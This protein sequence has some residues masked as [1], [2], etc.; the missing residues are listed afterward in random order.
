[1]GVVAELAEH[2]T[3][4]ARIRQAE[5]LENMGRL[6]GGVAHDFNNLLTGMHLYC[7]LLIETLEPAHRG[8]HY[9]EEIRGAAQ[10]AGA[11]VQQLLSLGR[12]AN[13]EPIP[14]SLNDVAQGMRNLLEHLI[15]KEHTLEFRLDCGIGVVRIQR[16]QAQQMLLN[17]V[18]NARDAM[19]GGGAI[20]IETSNCK[21]QVLSDRAPGM[22]AA[23][24]LSC[25]LLVVEDKGVGMNEETRARV[26]EPFFTTK[27]QKG[28]GLGM[29][30]VLEIVT[31]S[32]GLIHIESAPNQGTRVSVLLPLTA[33][34]ASSLRLHATRKRNKS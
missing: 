20:K 2:K 8:R 12:S 19:P 23:P 13:E 25:V 4:A 18:L 27:G 10:Q 34:S 32:G 11:L 30:T 14:L 17:L 5:A 28:T 31:R 16:A 15:G 21:V 33:G 3:R 26:F 1:M 24:C 7:D 6:T 22:D 9:A 29:T